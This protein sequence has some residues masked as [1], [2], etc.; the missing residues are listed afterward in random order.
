MRWRQGFQFKKRPKYTILFNRINFPSTSKQSLTSRGSHHALHPHETWFWILTECSGVTEGLRLCSQGFFIAGNGFSRPVGQ[1]CSGT[2]F[3]G[4]HHFISSIN[5]GGTHLV[6]FFWMLSSPPSYLS[7]HNVHPAAAA[8]KW[9]VHWL[10]DGCVVFLPVPL[11]H[12]RNSLKPFV[13]LRT[14]LHLSPWLYPPFI[15]L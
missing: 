11:I 9:I 5:L 1:E 2:G 4:G 15:W 6:C 14:G 13:P 10:Q 8:G 12:L 3:A 7:N